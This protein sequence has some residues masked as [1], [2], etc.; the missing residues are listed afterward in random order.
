MHAAPLFVHCCHCRWCQRETGSAFVINALIE[1]ERVS[2]IAGA[3]DVIL[4]PSASGQGQRIAR[5]PVCRIAVWSNY[6]GAGE[7]FRF[8][9]VGTLD[10]PDRFPPEVHIFTA[11]KQPWVILPAGRAGDAGL[12]RPRRAL[13]GGE[14][15]PPPGG[16]GAGRIAAPAASQAGKDEPMELAA[17]SFPPVP[18]GRRRDLRLDR[19]TLTFKRDG[20]REPCG[21]SVCTAVADP[22]W[23]GARLRTRHVYEEWHIQLEGTGDCQLGDDRFLLAPG[24]MVYVPSGAPHG[25]RPAATGGSQL[26]ISSPPGILAKVSSRMSSPCRAAPRRPTSGA[27]PVHRGEIRDRVPRPVLDRHGSGD[28]FADA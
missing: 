7:H 28:R 13:A 3:P 18:V 16:G 5:C 15:R 11:S 23:P 24:D 20:G 22:G 25:F 10:D 17:I 19:L 27:S 8:V 2:L 26:L 6:A 9:R 21:Y 14:P 12:L 1:T 4:T